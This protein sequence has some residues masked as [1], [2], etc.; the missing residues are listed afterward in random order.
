MIATATQ[1][2][3]SAVGG[4]RSDD[5]VKVGEGGEGCAK[6]SDAK[7]GGGEELERREDSDGLRA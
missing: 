3:N 5:S 7:D 6:S 1:T 4:E 2:A